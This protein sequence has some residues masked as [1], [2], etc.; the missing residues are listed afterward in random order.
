MDTTYSLAFKDGPF[1]RGLGYSPVEVPVDEVPIPAPGSVVVVLP[2]VNSCAE[3]E[4]LCLLQHLG[5]NSGF[6]PRWSTNSFSK[7]CIAIR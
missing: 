7:D 2:G 6:E 4:R 3:R 5:H 1:E